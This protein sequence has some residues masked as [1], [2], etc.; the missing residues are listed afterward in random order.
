MDYYILGCICS[1]YLVLWANSEALR[2]NISDCH[3]SKYLGCNLK[4]KKLFEVQTP[5]YLISRHENYLRNH[6]KIDNGL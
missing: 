1:V 6:Y 4:M 5:D 3:D 2:I